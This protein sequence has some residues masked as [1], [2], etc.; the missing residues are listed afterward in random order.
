MLSLLIFL[1]LKQN[2][3]DKYKLYNPQSYKRTRTIYTE[4]I[5]RDMQ[6]QFIYGISNK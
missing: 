2:F 6:M 5:Q 3:K 4:R 1:L